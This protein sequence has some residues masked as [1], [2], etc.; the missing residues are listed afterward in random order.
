[1]K[2]HLTLTKSHITLVDQFE[3]AYLLSSKFSKTAGQII[4]VNGLPS[5]GVR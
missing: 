2:N 5:E 3:V 4:S 1:M